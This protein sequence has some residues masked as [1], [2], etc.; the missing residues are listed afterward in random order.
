[1]QGGG[2]CNQ[3]KPPLGQRGALR[4]RGC[5]SAIGGCVL[6]EHARARTQAR[7]A[8]R[9]S[10][11]RTCHVQRHVPRPPQ[12]AR[13]AQQAALCEAKMSDTQPGHWA[14]T[15]T[16]DARGPDGWSGGEWG[17]GGLQL[18]SWPDIV[19]AA[20]A[21][22]AHGAGPCSARRHGDHVH[23]ADLHTTSALSVRKLMRCRGLRGAGG[24]RN[25]E[26]GIR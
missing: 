12:G 5:C 20:R 4:G 7:R 17:K 2:T 13:P 23:R 19:W 9:K 26:Q 16:S 24:A 6:R 10:A 15:E 14:A 18:S 11:T 1:M 3:T 21:I 22:S 25:Q 8:R